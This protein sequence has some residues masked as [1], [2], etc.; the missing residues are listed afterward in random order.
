MAVTGLVKIGNSS[1]ARDLT[2]PSIYVIEY[3]A[4]GQVTFCRELKGGVSTHVM[5]DTHVEISLTPKPV[6]VPV[7]PVAVEPTVEMAAV[8]QP[9]SEA[10]INEE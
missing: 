4:E 8:E 6:H 7:T 2:T 1:G 5:F 9:V 3:N 10:A